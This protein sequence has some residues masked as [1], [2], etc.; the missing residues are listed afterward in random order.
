MGLLT[1]ILFHYISI[2][3]MKITLNYLKIS[4]KEWR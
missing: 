2:N 3:M 1:S 4:T